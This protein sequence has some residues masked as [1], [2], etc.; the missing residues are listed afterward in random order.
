[1]INKERRESQSALIAKLLSGFYKHYS[2]RW[3]WRSHF[4]KQDFFLWI[5]TGRSHTARWEA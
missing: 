4:R 5:P 3:V 2:Y 1:L